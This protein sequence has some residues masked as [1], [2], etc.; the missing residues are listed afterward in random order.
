MILIERII[1]EAIERDASDIHLMYG[2]KPI[3]R[4]TRALVEIEDVKPL[5]EAELYDIYEYI[6]KGS[7]EKDEAYKIERKLDTSLVFEDIR[8][9]VNASYSDDKPLFT[10]RIIKN[11]LPK[12]EDLGLPEIVRSMTY[13][14]QGL[15]LVTG[16]TN[17]GKTTTLSALIDEINKKQNKKILTLESPIE[18]K[19]TSKNSIIIQKEVGPGKDSLNYSDGVKNALREDCD[20]LVVRRDS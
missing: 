11:E 14:P 9:R 19:H 7:V 2:L 1:K 18:Y 10:M 17:S 6:V 20:I 5:D 8:L 16:K 12:Y 3:L 15:M 4:I 13:Q